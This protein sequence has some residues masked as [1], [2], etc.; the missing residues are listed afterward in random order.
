M[1]S[2]RPAILLFDETHEEAYAVEL[3]AFYY[4]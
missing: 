2:V 1:Y 4:K 3:G